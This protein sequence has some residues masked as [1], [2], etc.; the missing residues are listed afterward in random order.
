M[1]YIDMDG[2]VADFK[3]LIV[4]TTGVDKTTPEFW[5]ELSEM[6]SPYYWLPTLEGS[7]KAVNKIKKLAK[8]FGLTKPQF[9]TSLPIITGNLATSH[10]DKVEWVFDNIG[11]YQVNVVH[12]WRLKKNFIFSPYDILI[13]DSERNCKD[14]KEAGGIAILHESWDKTILELKRLL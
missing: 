9:L 10:R 5:K 14:W 12:D 13:D 6:Q 7:K 3:S 2:V 8:E 11:E 1:I 4:E